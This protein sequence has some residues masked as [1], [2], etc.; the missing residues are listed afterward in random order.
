MREDSAMGVAI[1][2]SGQ[3]MHHPGMF[4]LLMKSAEGTRYVQRACDALGVS[5]GGLDALLAGETMEGCVAQ[6]VTCALGFGVWDLL[7]S[8]V[9]RPIVFAGY[10][11]GELI[12][13]ACAGSFGFET[14][15]DVSA[16]RARFMEEA[17]LEP[18]GLV[19]VSGI[20]REQIE[21]ICRRAGTHISIFNGEDHF[22]I[23]GTAT[24]LERV[25]AEVGK[26]MEAR[27][28]TLP[29]AVPSHT[30][31]MAG[32][33]PHFAVLLAASGLKAPE[34]PVISSTENRVV[35]T[36]GDEIA[37]LALHISR[38]IHWDGCMR[39]AYEMGAQIF[40]E[41]GPG[42][43]LAAITRRLL[44]E[45]RVHSMEEFRSLD[46]IAAWLSKFT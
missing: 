5:R 15:L 23:G 9:P 11:L 30:P 18:S 3:G 34:T 24:G 16:R 4:R 44:P 32:A 37:T 20:A 36:V 31:L 42:S 14:L 41:I 22:V 19:A 43:S 6:P 2:F 7:R 28:H 29:I 25:G 39:T 27:L 35:Y 45:C 10:S 46:G 12:A 21:R 13:Y 40:L 38:P 17:V 26:I 8:R 33:T 1:I